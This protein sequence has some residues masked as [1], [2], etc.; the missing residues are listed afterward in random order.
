MM[1]TPK[2]EFWSSTLG[3]HIRFLHIL[4][5]IIESDM[6]CVDT[7]NFKNPFSV[8]KVLKGIQ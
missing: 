7:S 8:Y 4:F 2:V 3:M 1:C 6:I 5:H